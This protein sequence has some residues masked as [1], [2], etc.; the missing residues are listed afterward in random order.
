MP[1][2]ATYGVDGAVTVHFPYDKQFI[3]RLKD[4]VP[5]R[6]RTYC[7]PAKA[8]TVHE[9]YRD[10][11][12]AM[13]VQWFPDVRWR[14]RTES[15]PAPTPIRALDQAFADLHLL[16]SAPPTLVEAAFRTMAKTAHPDKGGNEELMR[17]LNAAVET[18]RDRRVAS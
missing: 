13:L 10:R 15:R 16:P 5:A 4:T 6:Y 14:R 11:V 2:G 9:P 17:R 1:Y 7:P 3:E 18:L 12:I 8:W